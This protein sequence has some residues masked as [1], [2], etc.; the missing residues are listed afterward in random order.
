MRNR[1]EL[2]N[3]VTGTPMWVANERLEEYLAAGHKP[4]VVVPPAPPITK[5]PPVRKQKTK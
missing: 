1:T 4:A 3:K 5:K 2:I